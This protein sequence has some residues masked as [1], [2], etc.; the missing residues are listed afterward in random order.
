M[1]LSNTKLVHAEISWTNTRRNRSSVIDNVSNGLYW[2]SGKYRSRDEPSI[3]TPWT[4]WGWR[5]LQAQMVKLSSRML[6]RCAST[7]TSYLST[8]Y[9]LYPSLQAFF[10]MP[11]KLL[12]SHQCIRMVTLSWPWTIVFL[13]SQFHP[14]FLNVLSIAKL[15]PNHCLAPS[16]SRHQFDFRPQN[17]TQF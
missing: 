2:P 15:W 5:L 14:N 11:G 10:P 7:I 8:L 3:Y 4:P 1:H 6:Q 9:N 13:S 17:S 12:T 16:F